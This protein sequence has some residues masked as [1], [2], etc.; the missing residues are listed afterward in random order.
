MLK[1]KE[2][3]KIIGLPQLCET[4]WQAKPQEEN[5]ERQAT[6]DFRRWVESRTLK[7]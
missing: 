3:E 2:E 1:I 5:P 6:G 4:S 7:P